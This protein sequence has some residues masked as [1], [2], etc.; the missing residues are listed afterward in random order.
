M[1][2]NGSNSFL[3]PLPAVDRTMEEA[4]P[5]KENLFTP[6]EKLYLEFIQ[7]RI[8]SASGQLQGL[9]PL[10]ISPHMSRTFRVWVEKNS[11]YYN[12]A[13][14]DLDL[15]KIAC[16]VRSKSKQEVENGLN[17]SGN[18]EDRKNEVSEL[19]KAF[20]EQSKTLNNK[21]PFCIYLTKRQTDYLNLIIQSL[22]KSTTP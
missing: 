20:E 22:A 6:S 7:Y 11:Q 10:E 13:F 17:A 16:S 15:L 3:P 21:K 14:L 2:I 8:Q 12:P 4:P 1:D 19:T 18:I 5:V 9:T